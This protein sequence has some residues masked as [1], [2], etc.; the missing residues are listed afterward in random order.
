[1]TALDASLVPR[2]LSRATAASST[3][4]AVTVHRENWSFFADYRHQEKD[5]LKMYG[6]S[7]FT[8]AS[9]LPMPFDYATDEVD[10]GVRYAS[11]RT[12]FVS[13]SWYLSEFENENLSTQWQDPFDADHSGAEDDGVCAGTRITSSSQ[14]SLAAGYS[15]PDYRTVI[16]LSGSVGEI[17]QD[18]LLLPY[19]INPNMYA[20]DPLPRTSLGG[21]HRHDTNFSDIPDVTVSP[22]MVDSMSVIATTSATIRHVPGDVEPRHHRLG[23]ER[24]SRREHPI[25]L[26]TLATS[27]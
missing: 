4:A 1:M 12:G 11:S 21:S 27:R 2:S 24:R 20:A 19:T 9:I 23:P 5:G 26:R 16:S 6:G 7:S 8:N 22:K 15:F 3:S 14:V 13:L 25:Q 17:K 18:A 10:I